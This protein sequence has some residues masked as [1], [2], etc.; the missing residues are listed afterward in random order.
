[1]IHDHPSLL[2]PNMLDRVQLHSSAACSPSV[3][4][5]DDH[6][7]RV[8]G[9]SGRFRW[10]WLLSFLGSSLLL[11]VIGCDGQRMTME[12]L[13]RAAEQL[14]RDLPQGQGDTTA[15]QVAPIIELEKPNLKLGFIKLTDCAPLVIALEKGFFRDEGLQVQL[16]AQS[17]WKVLLDRVI[18]GQLDGAHMLAGQP[19]G[20][21]I[22]I[23][24]RADVITA[25]GLDYNGNAITVSN[26]LWKQMQAADPRLSL[27]Q[28][29]RPITAEPLRGIVQ[30][31]KDAG[32]P[33][34]MAMVF[35]VSTHNYELRYWLAAAGIHPGMYSAQ[36]VAGTTD[37]DVLLSVTPPPQMPSTLEA[38]TIDGYCVGE[39]WN[40]KAV[41]SGIGVPVITNAEIWKNNPEKV[42]GVTKEWD[43]KHR[44]TH[45]A[46]IK[47]LI[48][49]GKWLDA[50][51]ETGAF[52]NRAEAAR[53][54]SR[55]EYVGAEYQVIA[56]SMTGTFMFQT[57]D[58]RPMPEFNVFFNDFANYPHYS[59]CI[60]FLTQMRRWGQISEAKPA[61]W[62]AD[63]AAAIYK[64]EIYR[65]AAD[66]L[67]AEG[68]LRTTE[69]PP[70]EYDGYR[71][72]SSDFI[73]SRTFDAAD[74]IGYLRS[75]DIGMKD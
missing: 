21:S 75:F 14:L 68:H 40:Q 38:G 26:A 72:A 25:C 31:R 24:T 49:A 58:V 43:R 48:R 73:D 56:G 13:E 19:I 33:L 4:Q 63:T 67:I 57:T 41:I 39:P 51:D 20:A 8:S 27:P 66:A 34:T 47:A 30:A 1:M 28:P 70:P 54:L 12:D 61:Q 37:A 69:V 16:E 52:I 29:P 55:P 3:S 23:G 6:C 36:D 7:G 45:I 11:A 9:R 62:Y 74:P 10:S 44:Q 46:V 42:L 32:N 17:N 15:N 18:D 5:R 35:P 22:G 50:T 64:P 59:D 53:I 60:W 2:R 71:P 65:E